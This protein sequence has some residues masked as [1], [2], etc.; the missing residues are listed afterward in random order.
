MSSS[1]YGTATVTS[2]VAGQLGALLGLAL[3]HHLE[4][5]KL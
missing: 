5:G 2:D 4:V 1:K 3:G